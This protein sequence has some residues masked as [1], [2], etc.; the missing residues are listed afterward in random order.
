MIIPKKRQKGVTLI[1]LMIVVVIVALLAALGYPSYASYMVRAKRTE[2][3]GALLQYATE[4]EK[5][6]LSNNTYAASMNQLTGEGG[7]TLTTKSNTYT[8]SLGGVSAAGYTMTATYVGTDAEA[9][10]CKTF[11]INQNGDRD[12]APDDDC[13][14]K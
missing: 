7:A 5:F 1:E 2:G 4:Q 11:T 12:S 8:V 14:D 10:V 3:R 6:Y 13:W 9:D